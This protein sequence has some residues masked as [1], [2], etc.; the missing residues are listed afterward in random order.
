MTDVEVRKIISILNTSAH[1]TRTRRVLMLLAIGLRPY[2][3]RE[4]RLVDVH[5]DG[6]IES[7][8]LLVRAETTGL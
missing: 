3:L 5:I 7:S 2:E 8:Y 6:P 1:G 4:L